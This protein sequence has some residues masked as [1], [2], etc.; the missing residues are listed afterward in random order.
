MGL[1]GDDKLQDRR[2]DALEAHIR[3]LTEDVQ[4][5]WLDVAAVRIDLM[6]L[7]GALDEA[8][9]KKISVTDVDPD[10]IELNELLVES[11]REAEKAEAA[12]TESWATLQSGARESFQTLRSSIEQ[13]AARLKQG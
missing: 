9:D 7:Q 3:S 11:R 2:L 12:A 5:N 4:Q 8:L 6:K 1:F 13:A 10:L